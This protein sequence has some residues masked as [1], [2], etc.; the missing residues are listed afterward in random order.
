MGAVTTNRELDASV[1]H[2][3]E[4]G[5]EPESQA[6]AETSPGDVHSLVLNELSV[7]QLRQFFQLLDEW[8]RKAGNAPGRTQTFEQDQS[9]EGATDAG[10]TRNQ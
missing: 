4:G 9:A 6:S 5:A 1:V 8:D 3:R 10:P 7:S 2:P